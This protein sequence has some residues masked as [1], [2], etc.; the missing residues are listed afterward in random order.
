MDTSALTGAQDRVPAL[1]WPNAVIIAAIV[2]VAVVS[3]VA[4]LLV[5]TS[6]TYLIL[7]LRVLSGLLVSCAIVLWTIRLSNRRRASRLLQ[8][9][10]PGEAHALGRLELLQR[11]STLLGVVL[12][13]GG[14]TMLAVFTPLNNT[15]LQ[16]TSTRYFSA[17]PVGPHESASYS[18]N[19]ESRLFRNAAALDVNLTFEVRLDSSKQPPHGS[20]LVVSTF[21]NNRGL[22]FQMVRTNGL[23]QLISLI[24]GDGKI[25]PPIQRLLIPDVPLHQW[26]VISAV[27]QRSQSFRYFVGGQPVQTFTWNLPILSAAPTKLNVSG[28]FGGSV[29]HLSMT[30]S[31]F[32][33]DPNRIRFL[34]IRLAQGL[35]LLAIVS[36]SIVLC[37]RFLS[38]LVPTSRPHKPLVLVT[39]WTMGIGIAA[40]VLID[41]LRLQ[42]TSNAYAGRNTWLLSQ[43]PRFND[44]FQVYEILRSFNPYGIQ[45]GNYPP[46]GYWL[47]APFIWM[48]EY[49]ALF[50]MI[51]LTVGFIAWWSYRSFTAGLPIFGRMLVIVIV[52]CSLPVSFAVDR[53]NVDLLIFILIALGIAAVERLRPTL[54]AAC[55]GV[56]AAVKIYPIA[57]LLVFL[58]GRRLRYMTL[59]IV[60]AALATILS[61]SLLRN[62]FMQNVDGFRSAYSALQTQLAGGVNATYFNASI[63]G[64]LQGIGYAVD[65]G[66]GLQLVQNALRPLVLPVEAVAGL[67]LAAYLRWHEQ[68]L[69][70]AV[71]LI[72]TFF[73]LFSTL[74]YYYELLF[75]FIALALFVRHARPSRTAI[76]IA[77]LFGLTL[78]PHAYFYLGNTMIDVSVLTTAPL[79]IGITVAV[80]YDGHH[81][82]VALKDALVS[83]I[84]REPSLPSVRT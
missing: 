29:R 19:G 51:G 13:V 27:V 63:P 5:T 6:E 77:V 4:S 46:L 42:H 37:R 57:Y 43:Y 11:H 15:V 23:N 32:R 84:P 78:A 83:A 16:K 9:R 18:T 82:R 12:L 7:A 54:A 56:A 26:F 8:E 61:F 72:T 53:A 80:V 55:I 65:G 66:H 30:V 60:I 36:S 59:G 41:L 24:G 50:T 75:V 48:N 10:P 62:N 25:L 73:L 67:I 49:A 81:E 74:S 68:S 47:V 38:K 2:V 40:N 64:W 52:L 31:L 1:P 69:W 44:F 58:R 28:T 35:G 21:G 14:V 45:N 22:M 33:V 79:L 76:V 17:A 71:T 3:F 39:F 20:P 34:L 70:R